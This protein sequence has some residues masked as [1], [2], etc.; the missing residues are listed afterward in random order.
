ME[1]NNLTNFFDIVISGDEVENH[2]P[3]P[4]VIE[5]GLAALNGEK[6]LAI[7]IGDSRK[8]LGAAKNAGI[9]SVLIYPPEHK[10][11]YDL[12]DLKTYQPT[13]VASGFKELEDM[14]I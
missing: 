8:D 5:K 7:M 11:Y 1:N 12:D 3:H 6:E 10:L 13:F 4:E 14:I 2:K 9:D